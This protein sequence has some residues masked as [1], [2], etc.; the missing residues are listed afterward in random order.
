MEKYPI[1]FC[2]V[3]GNI[4]KPTK[5]TKTNRFPKPK[6]IPFKIDT[7]IKYDTDNSVL[8]KSIY[9]LYSTHKV[10]RN[11]TIQLNK[12]TKI[13]LLGYSLIKN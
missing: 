10:D 4:V 3:E 1:Y 11:D 2:T 13:K 8:T 12:I 9:S 7:P 5:P 6:L